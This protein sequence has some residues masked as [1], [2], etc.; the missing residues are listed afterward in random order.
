M[1]VKQMEEEIMEV[2]EMAEVKGCEMRGA[3]C[4]HGSRRVGEEQ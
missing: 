1:I 4:L 3:A 2:K